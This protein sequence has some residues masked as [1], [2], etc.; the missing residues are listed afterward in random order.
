MAIGTARL[1]S[2]SL[3]GFGEVDADGVRIDDHEL[4]RRL[5]FAGAHLNRGGEAADGDRTLEGPFHVIGRHRR[6]VM[7]GRVLRADGR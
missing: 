6:A 4:I 5:H 1:G 2:S 3:F 7:K